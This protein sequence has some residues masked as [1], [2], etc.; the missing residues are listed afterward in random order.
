MND[1][2]QGANRRNQLPIQPPPS[3]STSH[4][5]RSNPHTTQ[6]SSRNAS[7][8]PPIS[9]SLSPSI[10][11][12]SIP[13]DSDS[14][15]YNLPNI[16]AQPVEL[17]PLDPSEQFAG[18]G[19]PPGG[20]SAFDWPNSYGTEEYGAFYQ[21]QGTLYNQFQTPQ[22]PYQDFS[23][24]FPVRRESGHG[25]LGSNNPSL[26]AQ[27]ISM[28]S[29]A[30]SPTHDMSSRSPLPSIVTTRSGQKRK[31]SR[32]AAESVPQ[33]ATSQMEAESVPKRPSVSRTS[34]FAAQQAD[35]RATRR[36]PS[37]APASDAGKEDEEE[38]VEQSEASISTS[39]QKDVQVSMER[40][41]AEVSSRLGSVLPAGQVFV[42]QIGS[43]VFRLSG[44]SLSSDGTYY[45]SDFLVGHVLIL[46]EHPHISRIF[47]AN[48]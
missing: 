7:E 37:T 28:L 5:G 17:G 48:S 43:E 34:T 29:A 3:N 19:F 33:S 35:P 14:D 39:K 41:I 45:V 20:P 31:A 11:N 2:R 27:S 23:N 40:R 24:P 8:N 6:T 16:T 4:S 36:P 12:Q 38:G 1:P 46:L 10:L 42:I 18:Y 26:R 22:I 9:Q 30:Q 25:S 47:S 32:V 15:R 44:A 21:P 13:P